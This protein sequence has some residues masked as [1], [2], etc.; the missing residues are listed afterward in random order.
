MLK[1][2]RNRIIQKIF[3]KY[4]SKFDYPFENADYLISKLTKDRKEEYYN[5]VKR[6]YHSD[7]YRIEITELKKLFYKELAINTKSVDQVIGYRLSLL[8]IRKLENRF[9]YLSTLS[10]L[11]DKVDKIINTSN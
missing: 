8:F 1:K 10:S 4:Y 6:F 5:D 11:E 9:K 2:L 7:L 3:K